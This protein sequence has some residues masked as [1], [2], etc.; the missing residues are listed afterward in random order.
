ME[1]LNLANEKLIPLSRWNNFH[2]YP[3]VGALRQLIFRNKNEIGKV[4]V[5]MGGRLYIIESVFFQ[6]VAENGKISA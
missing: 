3:T 2:P 5:R 4:L 1:N 6:W